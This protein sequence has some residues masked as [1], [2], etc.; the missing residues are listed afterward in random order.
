MSET[1][2]WMIRRTERCWLEAILISVLLCCFLRQ[3][4]LLHIASL[5]IRVYNIG[6]LTFV[7]LLER[8]DESKM[9]VLVG[10]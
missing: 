5:F 8:H 9:K 6:C 2:D 4:T 10:I 3:E 1:F 7:A